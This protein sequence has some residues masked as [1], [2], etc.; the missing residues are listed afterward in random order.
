MLFWSFLIFFVIYYPPLFTKSKCPPASM[1]KLRKTQNIPLSGSIILPP[2][3]RILP[4]GS[5]ILPPLFDIDHFNLLSVVVELYCLVVEIYCLVVEVYYHWTLKEIF[6]V[7]LHLDALP[8]G[9][10]NFFFHNMIL[11]YIFNFWE[12]KSPQIQNF[13]KIL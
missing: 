8:V 3:R 11:F 9:I 4:P 2:G 10:S 6:S 7:F 13:M 1:T 5:G 12:K